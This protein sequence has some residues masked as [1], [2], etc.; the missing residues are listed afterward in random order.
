MIETIAENRV[1]FSEWEYIQAKPARE[2]YHNVGSPTV[3]NFKALVKMNLIKNCPVTVEDINI[4]EKIFGPAMSTLKGKTTCQT[5]KAVIRDEIELPDE[6]KNMNHEVDLCID[7]MY[8]NES[9][10]LTT[11]DKTI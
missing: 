5:P 9:P 8:I 11:I 4:A 10:F 6:L 3:D 1:G 7:V 2:L